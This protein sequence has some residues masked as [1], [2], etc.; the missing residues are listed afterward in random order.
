M[1]AFEIAVPIMALGL[2]GL[3]LSYAR[4]SE[5]RLDQQLA[6]ARRREE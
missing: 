3:G 2:I 1:T 6:K 5:R 4:W